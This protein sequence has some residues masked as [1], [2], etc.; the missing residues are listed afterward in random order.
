MKNIEKHD[1]TENHLKPTKYPHSDVPGLPQGATQTSKATLGA[2]PGTPGTLK[3]A[4]AE[5]VAFQKHS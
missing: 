4:P 5:N 3:G 1:I 2:H